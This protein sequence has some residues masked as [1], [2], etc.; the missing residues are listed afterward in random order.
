MRRSP[1]D[2]WHA[3][4]AAIA[5]P[6]HPIEASGWRHLHQLELVPT[7]DRALEIY[8][9]PFER[10]RLQPWLI[11][12]ADDKDIQERVG[13]PTATTKTYRHLFFD[14]SVFRDQLEKQLWVAKYAGTPEGQAFLQKA[15]L[16][17]VE[18]VA[19]V[20]GAPS[21]LEPATVVEQAMRD[22]YFRGQAIRSA[23]LSSP[24]TAAAYQLLKGAVDTSQ[25]M[26]KTRPANIT[27]VM[28]KLKSREM[29]QNVEDVELHGEIL[30]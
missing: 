18:A 2:R 28:I 23:R 25:L 14:I 6:E 30:H 19:H 1:D 15:V 9:E 3:V 16:F 13:L 4:K 26:N 5:E 20:L 17:G 29:T 21:K 24:D 10:E 22:L 7:I 27:D 11:A 12:G 8:E